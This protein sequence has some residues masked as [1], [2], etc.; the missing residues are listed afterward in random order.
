MV[1]IGR[2]I[3]STSDTNLAPE[4]FAAGSYVDVVTANGRLIA[5]ERANATVDIF[6]GSLARLSSTPLPHLATVRALAY[7]EALPIDLPGP[8]GTRDGQIGQNE[9][10]DLAFVG[11][12]G[13]VAIVDVTTPA[14]PAVIGRVPFD[15][16]EIFSLDFDAEQRRLF[17][18]GRMPVTTGEYTFFIIDLSGPDPFSPINK[19]SDPLD[20]RVTWRS[21]PGTYATGEMSHRA[22]RF[23]K[24]TRTLYI[25]KSAGYDTLRLD[26]NLTGQATYTYFRIRKNGVDYATGAIDLPIRGALVELRTAGTT[27]ALQTTNTDENGFYTFFGA[28]FGQSLEV[29]VTA[30]LGT[31]PASPGAQPNRTAAVVDNTKGYTI[32]DQKSGPFTLGP[33][34]KHTKDIFA[35]TTWNAGAKRYTL[36]DGAPFA[37]LDDVYQGQVKLRSVD[38]NIKYDFVRLAWSPKNSP[39]KTTDKPKGLLSEGAHYAGFETPPTIYLRGK[40]NNNT[41]EYDA[42]VV[43]HE[44]S[45]YIQDRFGRNDSPNG[46]H[47]MD[48]YE[49]PRLA[50]SE[51]FATAL[52]AMLSGDPV[53]A[54]TNGRAQSKVF[55]KNI[56][57]DNN[58]FDSFYTEFAVQEFL[59]DLYDGI[60]EEKDVEVDHEPKVKDG[61]ELGITPIFE[62]IKSVKDTGGFTTIFPFMSA[63]MKPYLADPQLKKDV[64]DKIVELAKGENMFFDHA[65]EF[66]QSTRMYI[67]LGDVQDPGFDIQ[68]GRLYTPVPIDGERVS[69]FGPELPH[70]GQPLETDIRFDLSSADGWANKLEE[71]VYFKFEAPP[72]DPPNPSTLRPYHVRVEPA[73][74]VTG[75][76]EVRVVERGDPAT[77]IQTS[78]LTESPEMTVCVP[79]GTH[80]VVVRA[81]NLVAGR[82]VAADKKFTIRINPDVVINGKVSGS[83]TP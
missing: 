60:A 67:Q 23:D 69:V 20:D 21:A 78:P 76:F 9:V 70:D 52:A 16:A 58:Q 81:F 45:H 12:V 43:L 57:T 30:A 79:S 17:V 32:W 47:H 68:I 46:V 62:A 61:V 22:V 64:A 3:P 44:W 18:G 56:E 51:G 13:G 41:D 7:T 48:D 36:R 31:P 59:W 49:D 6:D 80:G 54:D 33:T 75:F 40:E 73:A 34:T 35:K 25:G 14:S 15:N 27:A 5:I 77:P 50:F 37:I 74:G 29:V 53:Y 63:L 66:E 83:C 72:E 2:N 82:K 4:Q 39:A 55:A 8:D 19:D 38:P 24:E 42:Q 10:R 26:P 71:A 28:P 11:G 65:D 1:D